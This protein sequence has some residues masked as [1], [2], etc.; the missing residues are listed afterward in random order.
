MLKSFSIILLAFLVSSGIAANA[1]DILWM[2]D[3]SVLTARLHPT[4][5]FVYSS[6]EGLGII[7][8]D[9]FTGDSLELISDFPARS[10]EFSK[11]GKMLA[12]G[13]TKG[14]M[15][16]LDVETKEILMEEQLEVTDVSGFLSIED[17]EFSPNSEY[18]AFATWED[19]F[20]LY[21][22]QTF[23]LVEEIHFTFNFH[24]WGL[25]E[26]GIKDISF[27]YQSK[28]ISISVIGYDEAPSTIYIYNTIK[29]NY[30]KLTYSDYAKFNPVND[31][32]YVNN[33]S[34]IWIYKSLDKEPELL[35]WNM[36]RFTVSENGNYLIRWWGPSG[37]EVI[38]LN[39]RKSIYNKVHT[40]NGQEIGWQ[41]ANM[42]HSER[43]F[44]LED[45]AILMHDRGYPLAVNENIKVKKLEVYPN[46]TTNQ[47][48]L[49][50]EYFIPRENIKVFDEGGREVTY[51]VQ[52]NTNEEGITLIL[53][54]LAKGMYI[55]QIVYANEAVSYKILKGE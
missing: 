22:T 19:G 50:C 36:N 26:L 41:Y 32:L 27:D 51:L 15:L 21:E 8:R 49:P 17:I 13:D 2:S 1:E 35:E 28:N 23:K 44:L 39:K 7:K 34:G 53:D 40:Y 29:G 24:K 43:Y 18:L 11:N 38:D 42:D 48:F 54:K 9:K 12:A 55:L 31:E 16:V 33:P 37:F 30:E 52:I 6:Q 14:K 20:R 47:V 4:K 10:I 3:Y 45:G 5:D 25:Q 46:P